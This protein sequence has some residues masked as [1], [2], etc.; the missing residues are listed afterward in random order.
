MHGASAAPA[1]AARNTAAAYSGAG[2]RPAHRAQPPQLL[3]LLCCAQRA[4]C[5]CCGAGTGGSWLRRCWGCCWRYHATLCAAHH[6]RNAR[7]AR[8]AAWCRCLCAG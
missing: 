3:P 7:P 4:C 5:E 1:P 6:P 8:P 2:R